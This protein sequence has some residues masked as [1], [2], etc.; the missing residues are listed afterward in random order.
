MSTQHLCARARVCVCVCVCVCVLVAQLCLIL[1]N[2]MGYSLPGSSVHGIFQARIPEW[3]AIPFSRASSWTRDETWVPCIV[4]GLYHL[5]YQRRPLS[6]YT[7]F[8]K[9]YLYIYLASLS[10]G[11]GT[12]DLHCLMWHLSWQ[13]TDS[14]VVAWRL[15]CSEACGILVPPPGI[16]PSA[17]QGRRLTTEPPEKSHAFA[18]VLVTVP[19]FSSG[20]P[21]PFHSP[22]TWFKPIW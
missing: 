9:N 8:K 17:L 21:L 10:L 3:V 19:Q 13:G 2:P 18:F 4:D 12:R 7:L 20:E 1:C 6:M 5:S 22:V 16:K 15:S 11:C 14:P